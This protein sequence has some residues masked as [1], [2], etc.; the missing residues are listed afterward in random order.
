MYFFHQRPDQNIDIISDFL[1]QA[2]INKPLAIH[3]VSYELNNHIVNVISLIFI[4][5]RTRIL[6]IHSN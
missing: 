4:Y 6:E 5:F 3:L 1:C 2:I